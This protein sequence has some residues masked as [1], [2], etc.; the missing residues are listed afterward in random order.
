MMQM[1][2][3]FY[4]RRGERQNLIAGG[5]LGLPHFEGRDSKRYAEPMSPMCTGSEASGVWTFG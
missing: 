3:R 5:S 1:L 4:R 2:R